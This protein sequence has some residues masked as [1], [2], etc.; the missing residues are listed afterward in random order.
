MTRLRNHFDRELILLLIFSAFAVAALLSPGFFFHAHDADHTVFYLIEFDAGIR[1]GILWPRWSPDHAMGYGYPFWVVYAPLAYYAAEVFHLMGVG[2]TASIKIVIAL[3]TLFG[4]WGMYVLLRR[5][6]GRNPIGRGAALVGGLIYVYAPYHLLT[7]Y[8]RAAFAEYVAMAWFPWVLL[9]FDDVV[10]R[11]GLRRIALAALALGALFLT[12]SAT[13]MVFTTFLAFYLLF[14]LA[15]KMIQQHREQE[16]WRQVLLTGVRVAAAG[17]LAIGLAAIFLLPLLA[18]QGYVQQA[19]WLADNYLYQKHFVY[20]SQFTDPFWGYGFSDDPTGPNDGMSFQLGIVG[21]V[22]AL[23]AAV[24]GLRRRS[25]RRGQTA[26]FVAA[27]LAV[28][29]LM[30]PVARPV[31]DAIGPAALIQFPWRLLSVASLC[32]AILAG[33]AVGNLLGAG[34]WGLGTGERSQFPA[35]HVLALVV[36]LASLAFTVPQYTDIE[37]IDES[38][39][40][41]MRF[42]LAYPDMIGHTAAVQE[43]FTESPLLPQYLA[44]E[45]LQK[46]V[47]PSG[48]GKVENSAYRR[49]L[50]GRACEPRWPLNRVILYLRLS[51]LAGHGGRSASGPPD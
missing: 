34:D 1:D 39:Q 11:G 24:V 17:L 41:I 38:V 43:S 46:A 26:F 31:W 44:G 48:G 42:E 33:A 7:V 12:H 8:V 10:E 23:T 16:S 14:A 28:L 20:P 49:L 29:L 30:M 15:R 35:A 40:S 21:V 3:S 51:R 37:P 47:L 4:G 27:L 13:L 45:P 9:A 19:D 25:Y 36:V 18:E 22:L 6:W 32:L 50:G 5:W 2:F